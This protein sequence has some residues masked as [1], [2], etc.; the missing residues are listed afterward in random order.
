MMLPPARADFSPA[1]G[2]LS[3]Q[4]G[5]TLKANC[6]LS[7]APG[8]SQASLEA[9]NALL[10]RL[11][12]TAAAGQQDALIRMDADGETIFSASIRQMKEYTLASFGPAGGAYIT[13]PGEKDA[14]SLLTDQ[15][16]D[17]PVDGSVLAFYPRVAENLYAVLAKHQTAKTTGE[18]TSI[19]NTAGSAAYETYLFP[20]DSLTPEIWQEAL[21]AA[22]PQ[23]KDALSRQP[24]LYRRAEALLRGLNFSGECRFKRFLDKEGADMGM[25]FT[26]SAALDGDKRKVTLY[27]GYTEGMGGYFSLSLPAAKGNNNLKVTLEYKETT[28]KNGS[29][30]FTASGSF[31]RTLSGETS[32]GQMEISLKNQL[33][34]GREAWTGKITLTRTEN[35]MKTTWTLTPQLAGDETGLTG[36]VAFTRQEGKKDKLKGEITLTLTGWAEGNAPSVAAARDLRGMDEAA[37]RAAVQGEMAALTGAAARLMRALPEDVRVHLTH[38]LRTDAWMNGP[39]VPPADTQAPNGP[40]GWIVEEGKQE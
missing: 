25:Q 10:A 28:A 17:W 3:R 26:G 37:A 24:D 15:S 34:S 27:G 39:A 20:K 6:T 2:E 35:R 22:L 40:E 21:D 1:Y 7:A 8:L 36:T 18:R 13:A 19:R 5:L 16:A 31:Q 23:I 11:T 14:L 33:E 29:R 32:S 4:G 9:V 38:E 30:T 12:L